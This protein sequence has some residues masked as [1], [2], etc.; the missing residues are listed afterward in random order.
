MAIGL[1]RSADIGAT[2]RMVQTLAVDF[3]KV[4]E[5]AT[6]QEEDPELIVP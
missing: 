4:P 3:T 2:E 1:V 5:P 6:E